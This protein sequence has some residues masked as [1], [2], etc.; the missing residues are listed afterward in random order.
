MSLL[1]ISWL[2]QLHQK[3]ATCGP[4]KVC[5]EFG[6]S[7]WQLGC[8]SAVCGSWKTKAFLYR[9]LP[10]PLL[11]ALFFD[12][13]SLLNLPLCVAIGLVNLQHFGND[14][15]RLQEAR[16]RVREQGEQATGSLQGIKVASP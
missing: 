2:I 1:I 5:E 6:F 11:P 10:F 13:L 15:Q 7:S 16:K 14:M 3:L 4:D 12:L 8:R 9:V